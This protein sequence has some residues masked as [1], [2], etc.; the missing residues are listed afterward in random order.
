MQARRDGCE[1]SLTNIK[2]HRRRRR[3]ST[4]FHLYLYLL[5]SMQRQRLALRL[6]LCLRLFLR[7]VALGIFNLGF[8]TCDF[9]RTELMIQIEETLQIRKRKQHYY[10]QEQDYSVPRKQQSISIGP[11]LSW[12]CMCCGDR[13]SSWCVVVVLMQTDGEAK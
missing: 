5:L 7:H 11:V 12:C 10:K 2:Y 6:R 9:L 4:R 1:S 8:S 13:Y 3:D